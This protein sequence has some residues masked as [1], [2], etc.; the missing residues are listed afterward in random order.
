MEGGTQGQDF[1]YP[2]GKVGEA[3]EGQIRPQTLIER[4]TLHSEGRRCINWLAAKAARL[5][6]YARLGAEQTRWGV[7]PPGKPLRHEG[8]ASRISDLFARHGDLPAITNINLAPDA[9]WRDNPNY[10]L[11]ETLTTASTPREQLEKVFS[12]PL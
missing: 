10:C 4:T 7:I 6:Q 8:E 3:K 2:E 5:Q 11:H 12:A 1:G 9:T